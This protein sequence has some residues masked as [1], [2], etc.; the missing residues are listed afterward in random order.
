MGNNENQNGNLLDCI[1][2]N[3]SKLVEMKDKLKGKEFSKSLL[4]SCM[5]V[6]SCPEFSKAILQKSIKE[7]LE[8]R[9]ITRNKSYYRG[10]KMEDVKGICIYI[11]KSS[12]PALELVDYLFDANYLGDTCN[13][14]AHAVINPADGKIIQTLPWD[15]KA[16]H[17][18]S[19]L[20]D[21]HIG[22][23][24]CEPE[25]MELGMD[26]LLNTYQS[27]ILLI[28]KLSRSYMIPLKPKY[29]VCQN[30][31]GAEGNVAM[32]FEKLN[33]KDDFYA[34]VQEEMNSGIS[35]EELA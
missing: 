6:M 2:S 33:I 19:E 32:Y 25:G 23:L 34:K 29:I 16:M 27:L 17:H 28:A 7:L 15:Y 9:Y 4:A 12:R 30:E 26:G 14:S 20:D 31:N 24:I 1:R 22:I 8:A 5:V 35:T 13:I 11:V 10:R 3:A 18:F 21:S